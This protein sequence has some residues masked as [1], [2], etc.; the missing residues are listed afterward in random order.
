MD[1]TEEQGVWPGMCAH[2]C[3]Q[4]CCSYQAVCHNECGA[5]VAQLRQGGLIRGGGGRREEGRLIS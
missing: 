3:C 2:A 1:S 5:V 4:G